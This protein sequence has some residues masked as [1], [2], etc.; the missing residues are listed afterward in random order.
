MNSKILIGIIVV[1]IIRAFIF[2][3]KNKLSQS[4][5]QPTIDNSQQSVINRIRKKV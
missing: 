5:N 2:I 1:L 3:G 4:V